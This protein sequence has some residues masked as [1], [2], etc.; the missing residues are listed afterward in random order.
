MQ[1][2]A[3]DQ[4]FGALNRADVRYLVVGGLAVVAHGYF[5]TTADL[6]LVIGLEESNI[7]KGLRA[8]EAIGYRMAI[9]VTVEA[10]ADASNREQWR[11][12]KGMLVLKMWNDAYPLNPVDIFVHEPFDMNQEWE[13]AA[14][15]EWREGLRVPVV[16]KKTLIAMKAEAARPQDLADIAELEKL[17]G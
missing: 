11:R 17:D 10:F 15:V 1:A 6:D 14:Q 5:R 7:I 3:L 13:R 2:G 8:L 12:E 9:P 16:S 4:I